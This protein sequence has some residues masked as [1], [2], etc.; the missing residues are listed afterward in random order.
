MAKLCRHF[1]ALNR[2][3]LIVYRR[4]PICAIFE[5]V[6]PCG[7]MC[8]MVWL[9]S[10][11]RI[12]HTDLTSLEKYKHPLFPALAY[13]ERTSWNWDPPAVTELEKEFMAFVDYAPRPP[14]SPGGR[15]PDP[16]GGRDPFNWARLEN[17]EST[18]SLIKTIRDSDVPFNS[19]AD[20]GEKQLFETRDDRPPHPK[21][22]DIRSDDLM[23]HNN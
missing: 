16:P 20:E 5:L 11:V 1:K 6:L 23:R 8:L 7:L 21:L 17:L 4:T 22:D 19:T 2:K 9:R 12:K 3:N 15:E 10:M 18:A 14:I 13:S